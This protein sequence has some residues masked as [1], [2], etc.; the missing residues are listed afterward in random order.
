MNN[1]LEQTEK[2]LDQCPAEHRRW[3]W[4]FLNSF[5]SPTLPA[6]RT[7]TQSSAW[8]TLPTAVT[9]PR[10]DKR[11]IIT[12]WAQSR[13]GPFPTP[14][15]TRHV[16]ALAF[17]PD[18]Q[19]LGT[20]CSQWVKVWDGHR[21]RGLP[22]TGDH[23]L[24]FS[25]DSRFHLAS[26]SAGHQGLGGADRQAATKPAWGH[27]PGLP[28]A[29]SPDGRHLTVGGFE[30]GT[31]APR[32]EGALQVWD[33]AT[34]KPIGPRGIPGW[35][36]PSPTPGRPAT[37]GGTALLVPG[38]GRDTGRVRGQIEATLRAASRRGPSADAGTSPTRRRIA[39]SGSGT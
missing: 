16:I 39:P 5:A 12:L 34:G 24:T 35:S 26:P 18:G 9:S 33:V 27:Q 21:R 4:H 20:V 7:A 37:G 30:G 14:S 8:R 11:G 36:M 1:R 10:A 23:W 31:G 19:W 17:S 28:G 32:R 3:E 29:F 6:C 15:T 25:P 38:D 2:M 13:G 22:R